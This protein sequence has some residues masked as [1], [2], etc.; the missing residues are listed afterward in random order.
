MPIRVDDER[1]A[2]DVGGERN[3]PA[4][5]L[6]INGTRQGVP[7]VELH[8]Q[9]IVGRLTRNDV[10]PLEAM[11]RIRP[12]IDVGSSANGDRRG[13]NAKRFTRWNTQRAAV[14][15]RHA[16]VDGLRLTIVTE[17]RRPIS[18]SLTVEHI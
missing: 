10:P 18:L 2:T 11:E 12:C 14:V 15:E 13:G 8:Q 7:G 1:L 3:Q 6:C 9:R 17:M 4:D 5:T 16:D